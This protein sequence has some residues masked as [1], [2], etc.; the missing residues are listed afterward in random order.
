MVDAGNIHM[1]KLENIV[2]IS[3]SYC[4]NSKTK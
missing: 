2:E 3:A 4:S 1:D